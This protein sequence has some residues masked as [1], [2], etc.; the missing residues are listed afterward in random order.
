MKLSING[1]EL[2]SEYPL[3]LLSNIKMNISG[4]NGEAIPGEIHA[5]II[6]NSTDSD[7]SFYL[8][9]TSMPPKAAEFFHGLLGQR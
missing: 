5:K 3:A 9:F 7:N 6:A 2:Y 8:R 1:G 4:I